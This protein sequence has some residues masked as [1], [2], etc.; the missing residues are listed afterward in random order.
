MGMAIT[1]MESSPFRFC[2]TFL[3]TYVLSTSGCTLKVARCAASTTSESTIRKLQDIFAIHGLPQK[4]VTDNGSA[5]TSTT[6]KTFMD[7]NGI[8]H[9]RSALHK[10]SSREGSA[11]I[12]T[13]FTTDFWRIN[14][15]E[16]C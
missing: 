2:W 6:F 10:W 4:L 7:Q 11:N 12:Q 1:A 9:I 5:F 3:R 14:K 13:E 8:I 16:A 15:G